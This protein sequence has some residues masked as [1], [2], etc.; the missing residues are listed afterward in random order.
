[1]DFELITQWLDKLGVAPIVGALIIAIATIVAARVVRILT[2]KIALIAS[3]RFKL[4]KKRAL[5]EVLRHPLWISVILIGFLAEVQWLKPA[6][7]AGFFFSAAGQTG[8]LIVWAI[9]LVKI[10]GL[11]CSR[12]SIY[13]PAESELLRLAENI[14]MVIVGVMGTLAIMGVWEIN[15]TPL[16][17]SAGLAGII[18]A[19]AAKDALGNFFG[20]ISLFLDRPFKRGDYIVLNSGERGK[21]VDI[22]L[23]ST[24]I[25]TRDDV[26]I[27]VP[28]S[29]MISTKIINESAPDPKMRIRVKVSV[30]L[31]SDVDQVKEVLRTVARSNPL[32]L[33]EPKPRVRFRDFGDASMNFELL[34]WTG[35]PKDKGKLIDQL[36]SGVFKEFNQAG[37]S[38]STPQ[39]DVYIH[40]VTDGRG[41]GAAPLMA[42]R[43]VEQHVDAG[44][45]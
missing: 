44:Q 20:G 34:C 27:S 3:R 30:S 36:Y 18:V 7:P 1:M 17:A 4:G 29:I 5:F 12:L 39:A 38:I 2:D 28:N 25:V 11:I 41:D 9:V 40:Q 31:T 24:K 21:V 10:L 13:Y 14:G 16:I 32:V 23:R 45:R 22:G 15:L 8:L 43:H 35:N 42:S 6:S 33:P 37:I 19:L 26:L